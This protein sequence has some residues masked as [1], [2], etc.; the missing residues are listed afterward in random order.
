MHE[1]E[2]A[3]YSPDLQLILGVIALE[4]HPP[5]SEQI[6]NV[7]LRS[8]LAAAG[9]GWGES[10]IRR[11]L[12]GLRDQGLVEQETSGAWDLE[13]LEKPLLLE[14]L[15]RRV[16]QALRSLAA[17]MASIRY[18]YDYG[19]PLLLYDAFLAVVAEEPVLWR[20]SMARIEEYLVAAGPQPRASSS[21]AQTLA[22]F[23][24]KHALTTS[25]WT[26]IS[27][28][29]RV[30]LARVRAY[31]A[32]QFGVPARGLPTALRIPGAGTEL[33]E[34]LDE[35]ELCA[36]LVE[37]DFL[38]AEGIR[39][40]DSSSV[41]A[42]K[43]LLA[44]L[45]GSDDQALSL[46]TALPKP[47]FASGPLFPLVATLALA[48]GVAP[49]S[50]IKSWAAEQ[51]PS[52]LETA[53]ILWAAFRH[54][55]KADAAE[56]VSADL[57]KTD[58]RTALDRLLVHF[59]MA[60][61]GLGTGRTPGD[62][63]TL[64]FKN[65][66]A[67]QGAH[68]YEA[69]EACTL[70]RLLEDRAPHSA[71]FLAVKSTVD[72]SRFLCDLI[73]A[74]A[75][76][77]ASLNRLADLKFETAEPTKA[78]SEDVL[79]WLVDPKC[80]T[81]EPALRRIL[82]GGGWSVPRTAPLGRLAKGDHPAIGADDR[83]VLR[84]LTQG[85][86]GWVLD[87]KAALEALV[88]HPRL[89]LA[90]QPDTPLTLE[91]VEVELK[92][93]E[94]RSGLRFA[95]SAPLVSDKALLVKVASDHWQVQLV[96]ERLKKVAQV[97]G[98]GL[99][100]PPEAR[101]RVVEVLGHLAAGVQVRSPLLK[102]N[103]TAVNLEADSHPVVLLMPLG[104]GLSVEVHVRPLGSGTPL[105]R[106]GEGPVLVHATIADKLLTATRDLPGERRLWKAALSL[107]P[108]LD[109][110]LGGALSLDLPEP[111]EAL[112]IL[113]ELRDLTGV[114]VEWPQGGRIGLHRRA[115]TGA[116][117]LTLA[118][119][120]QWLAVSGQLAV[121]N[122][123]MVEFRELLSQGAPGR[124]VRMA[125][126]DWLELESQLV[127]QLEHLMAVAEPGPR[128]LRVARLALA[129][130]DLL[131]DE[132]ISSA[133]GDVEG[134]RRR[135]KQGI[136]PN[137]GLPS[138]LTV[139]L[140]P[141]QL[142]GFRWLARLAEVGAGAC[143][144]DDMGLGKTVQAIALLAHRASFG[145]SLV[146][147]PTSVAPN[148]ASEIVRFDRH[149]EPVLFGESSREERKT[150]LEGL[151]AGQVLVATYGLVV[152]EEELFTARAWNVA[153]L[154]EAQAVKNAQAKRTKVIH[155]LNAQ[156]RLAVTGTPLQNHLG[157]LWALFEFLNPGLLGMKARFQDR[158]WGP[159]EAH[160]DE[161]AR[162]SLQA[163]V[164]PFLLRR[165][166]NQVLSELPDKTESTLAVDLYSDER[167]FYE[168]LRLRA[169]EQLSAGAPQPG[170]QHL[171]VLS[172]LMKLRR[173][174]CHPALAGGPP[175]PSS[176]KLDQMEELLESLID[177]GH[178]TLVFSQFTDHLS[179]I[180][181][182]L[183][184]RGWAYEYLDGSTPG[185]ERGERVA[186]FQAGGAPVFL[187]SLQA[188][189]TGLNLTA[190]DYVIHMDP[191]WNPAVEDQAS[192][193]AHRIGQIRPVTIYRL[194]AR[195]T[196]EERIVAL[197]RT[198]RDLAEALLEG[199]EAAGRL[200]TEELL[201]LME[202]AQG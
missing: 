67:S 178:Q 27:P 159:I 167:A 138:S 191:W 98:L 38:R 168:A 96:T 46:L 32:V 165:T 152:S 201:Q 187:I 17:K 163:L 196:I 202:T 95:F 121:D 153:V 54:Q 114:V 171:L 190:A 173:A 139:E 184:A 100:V 154:D 84:A 21:W 41:R 29:I 26:E 58:G 101:E 193:R 92:V 37:G 144:A 62:A 137:L 2:F 5:R 50:K 134:W 77:E 192:D 52:Y 174:C 158:Y 31:G 70:E 105:L 24:L 56:L 51:E 104:A 170:E 127:R 151:R 142:E 47:G 34:A 118:P 147:A 135:W 71:E 124:F 140:R 85:Y 73:Q 93:E 120:H 119:D 15:R 43:V 55:G 143:L 197:H 117:R 176:S 33:D 166:K 146:V 63:R 7:L 81:A 48:R 155:A 200:G 8:G 183:E 97:V 175:S 149:L 115:V 102:E 128:G 90:A 86:Y 25:V 162:R 169:L 22:G 126:G 123:R 10:R 108:E 182:R 66:F 161:G 125:D 156:F 131:L 78:A 129:S 74:N 40:A 185:R 39:N 68:W 130:S 160:N 6:S 195:D 44:Y 23:V 61:N 188:G 42:S 28:R 35:W 186:R 88:G 12:Q 133:T 103:S 141:Y 82:R 16:P 80:A 3:G 164:R 111:T 53:K 145:P 69:E 4:F 198:K 122:H 180:R 59:A 179:L 76:W 91:G 14:E 13:P 199:T 189:G 65:L 45:R 9:P 83:P 1:A 18:H 177:N 109:A 112:A 75:V 89:F 106:P 99:T 79:V 11:L 136:S 19:E 132:S 150:L 116:L 113:A 60:W 172:Q 110:G 72:A 30:W 20:Q 107:C 94:V 194:V 157:E 181:H 64:G 148:W 36:A 49:V 57:A 87:H